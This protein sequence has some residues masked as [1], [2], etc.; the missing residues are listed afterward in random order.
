M[1]RSDAMIARMVRRAAGE[2]GF[3]VIEML[4]SMSVLGVFFV[5]F[6]TVVSSSIHHGSQIQEEA[7]LQT[8]VRAGV[9]VL[10]ADLRQATIADDT[11]LSR[12]STAT[13]TQ[14]TF[15]SPDRAPQMHLRRISFQVT[16]GKLQRALATST[17][18][19]EPWSI[20]AL[21][22]WSTVARSIVTTGTPVFTYFDANGASTSVAANV[23]TVRIRVTVATAM[24]ADR[25]F[26]YDT[27]VTLRPES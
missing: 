6:A 24:N 12:I 15:L 21:S 10:A 2:D 3:T 26:T 22:A 16:G 4:V 23:R 7:I 8:E 25:Q 20:P 14:L 9:D 27:R 19:T 11:T 18:T 17:N 13:G 1:Y 5:V